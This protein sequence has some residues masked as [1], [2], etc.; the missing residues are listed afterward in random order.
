MTPP[1]AAAMVL[2]A[3]DNR[4]TREMYGLY[5]QMLGYRVEAAAD[6]EEAVKKARAVRPDL[7][8]MDLEMPR[9]DGWGA[10]RELR[11][12]RATARVPIIVVTGH[13]FKTHLKHA[14]IAEGAVSFL[15]K[16]CFPDQLAREVAERLREKRPEDRTA[17]L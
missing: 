15:M 2:I 17:A 5:L 8:I 9:L 11:A 16:P 6:G 7:I 13:D 1:S 10:M 14:A 12:R 4:D 3:E